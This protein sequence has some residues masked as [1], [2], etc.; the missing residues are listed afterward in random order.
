MELIKVEAVEAKDGDWNMLWWQEVIDGITF[1][2]FQQVRTDDDMW[3]PVI[4]AAQDNF[5]EKR[6]EL[7][8]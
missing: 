3:K 2:M 6:M 8:K 5:D 4:Q 7:Q 1:G